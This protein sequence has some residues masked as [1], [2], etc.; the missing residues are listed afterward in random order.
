MNSPEDEVGKAIRRHL[1][2]AAGD[3]RAGVTYRLQQARAAALARANATLVEAREQEVAPADGPR[4]GGGGS[5]GGRRPLF[6]QPRAWLALGALVAAL[7][8]YQQWTAWQQ[9]QELEDLDAALL[10]SDLPIDAYLDRGFQQWLKTARG[11]E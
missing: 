10:A 6:L 4:G 9:M 7:V 3:V 11:A 2:Q 5:G 8:G 1:D